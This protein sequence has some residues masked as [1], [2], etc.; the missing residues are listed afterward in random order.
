MQQ[1]AYFHLSIAGCFDVPCRWNTD[2]RQIKSFRSGPGLSEFHGNVGWFS[3]LN[4]LG[5]GREDPK[6][7][8]FVRR[9]SHD[10]ISIAI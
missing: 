6:G 1:D 5:Q 2:V 3:I 4:Q 8:L 9:L 7:G 10:L